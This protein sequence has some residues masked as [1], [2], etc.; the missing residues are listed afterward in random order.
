MFRACSRFLSRSST[1]Q[2]LSVAD[3]CWFDW[4][5]L[6]WPQ[7][8]EPLSQSHR[9]YILHTIDIEADILLL[10]ERLHIP[11]DAL[12]YFRATNRLLKAGVK[13]GMTLYDIAVICCRNDDCGELPSKLE[14]MMCMAKEVA[15]AAVRNGR[16]HHTAASRALAD[17]LRAEVFVKPSSFSK[18]KSITALMVTTTTTTLSSSSNSSYTEDHGDEEDEEECEE[19]AAAVVAE[20][21]VVET[22]NASSPHHSSSH[23]RQRAISYGNYCG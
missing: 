18:S 13:A 6:D 4:C 9:D 1:N 22:K 7:L 19:W 5:W 21:R 23:H 20:A 16:W 12:D 8:K 2:R 11:T 3:V 14:N 10:Q 17:Q 15:S